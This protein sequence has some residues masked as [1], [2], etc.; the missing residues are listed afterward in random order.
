[1]GKFYNKTNVT[2]FF[3][4]FNFQKFHSLPTIFTITSNMKDKM[5]TLT[6][7]VRH[8]S[9]SSYSLQSDGASGDVHSPKRNPSALFSIKSLNL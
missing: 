5:R 1:M 6:K 4:T 8:H 2:G 9:Y 7:Y 3:N